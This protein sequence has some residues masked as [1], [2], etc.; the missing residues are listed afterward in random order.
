MACQVLP[1]RRGRI[2]AKATGCEG[3]DDDDVT[4][5][6][7]GTASDRTPR[8]MI[9]FFAPDD[10]LITTIDLPVTGNN[11]VAHLRFGANSPTGVAWMRVRVGGS[12]AIDNVMVELE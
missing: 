4:Q 12:A 1:C 9:E 8:G 7:G 3:Y 6:E 10:T 5:F 11:G 2:L